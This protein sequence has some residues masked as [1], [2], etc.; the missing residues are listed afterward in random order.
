MTEMPPARGRGRPGIQLEDV[1]RACKALRKQGRSIGPMNVRLE[2][3]TGSY[4]TITKHLR[5]LGL[6][7]PRRGGQRKR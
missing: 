6:A 1:L 3:G 2:L 5:A 4:T 7:P